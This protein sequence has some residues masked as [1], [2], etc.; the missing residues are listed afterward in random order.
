M[1]LLE[2][3]QHVAQPLSGKLRELG[4]LMRLDR[5]GGKYRVQGAPPQPISNC[6]CIADGLFCFC[7]Q[8]SQRARLDGVMTTVVECAAVHL[9]ATA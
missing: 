9:E 5:I 3:G 4:S 2:P 6:V 7:D 1:T 8:L